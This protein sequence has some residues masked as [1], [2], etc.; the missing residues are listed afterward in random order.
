MFHAFEVL[1]RVLVPKRS[2][3]DFVSLS[4]SEVARAPQIGKSTVRE[5]EKALNRILRAHGP[6]MA[7]LWSEVTG[8]DVHRLVVEIE[9]GRVV[10][11]DAPG[12]N[13]LSS[14]PTYFAREVVEMA[15]AIAYPA[16]EANA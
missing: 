12:R 11:D 9:T 14:T 3:S 8:R 4:T 2:I 5:L 1:V 16:D 15:A 10:W 6:E 7:S 13:L